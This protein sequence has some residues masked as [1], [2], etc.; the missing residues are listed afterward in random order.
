MIRRSRLVLTVV[1][2]GATACSS[3]TAPSA[4]RKLSPDSKPLM[5]CINGWE[6]T[7]GVWKPC[8]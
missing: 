7:N 3:P 1:L 6:N 4:A 8:G 2:L 5:E